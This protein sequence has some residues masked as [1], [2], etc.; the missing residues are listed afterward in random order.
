[1]SLFYFH[2]FTSHGRKHIG[3]IE[4]PDSQFI[5]PAGL[6]LTMEFLNDHVFAD[7]KFGSYT[8]QATDD[9]GAIVYDFHLVRG[10]KHS[11]QP[12]MSLH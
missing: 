9:K 1:M 10:A 4:L 7:C 3:T 6:K 12:M 8:I 5:I 2:L 11:G